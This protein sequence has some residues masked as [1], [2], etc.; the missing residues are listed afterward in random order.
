MP[1]SWPTVYTRHHS[2]PGASCIFSWRC[3]A[4]AFNWCLNGRSRPKVVNNQPD[5]MDPASSLNIHNICRLRCRVC[6]TE[7]PHIAVNQL[8]FLSGPNQSGG[9]CQLTSY[10]IFYRRYCCCCF[11]VL[12]L[13]I[14]PELEW[15]LK[16]PCTN[17]LL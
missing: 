12:K 2:L 14:A 3:V 16:P 8:I 17:S 7:Q 13:F 6:A 10:C 5:A 9:R 15:F 4:E 11:A 1:C